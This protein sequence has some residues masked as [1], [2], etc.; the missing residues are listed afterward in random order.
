MARVAVDDRGSLLALLRADR[1]DLDAVI[2]HMVR[3][4]RERELALYLHNHVKSQLTAHALRLGDVAAGGDTDLDATVAAAI[5]VLTRPLPDDVLTGRVSALERLQGIAESWEG[6]AEVT[7]DARDLE[8]TGEGPLVIAADVV[9]EAVANAVR[10]G[11]ATSIAIRT[12]VVADGD[13][14]AMLLEVRDNGQGS[15]DMPGGGSGDPA[16]AGPGEPGLGSAWLDE[17]APGMW[18]RRR[19]AAGATLEVRIPLT[20]A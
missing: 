3:Q 13:S 8:A 12:R 7:V 20:R 17:I 5:R 10:G 2:A 18:H 14:A 6:I 11:G 19:D 15:A 9:A 1:A 16:A 4:R